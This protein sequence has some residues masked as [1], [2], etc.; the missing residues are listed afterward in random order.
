[1][2]RTTSN[3]ENVKKL[4]ATEYPVVA[5]L[6]CVEIK[7][8]DDD[9][10]LFALAGFVTIMSKSWAW[11][12]SETDRIARA[13][14]WQKAYAETDWTGCMDCAGIIE[15][16]END[17]DTREAF[18]NFIQSVTGD[19]RSDGGHGQEMTDEETDI[20]LAAGSNPTC[21]PDILYAQC[22]AVID[23]THQAVIDVLQKVEV[24]SNAIEVIHD[25]WDS[26][27]VLGT[28]DEA[29]GVDGMVDLAN[30][31]LEAVQE[32]YE[33]QWSETVGEVRDLLAYDLFCRCRSDCIINVDRILFVYANRIREYSAVPPLSQLINFLEFLAGL[34]QDANIVVYM[35]HFVAWGL[36]KL[37]RFLFGRRYDRILELL[38]LMKADEPSNDWEALEALFG[39]CQYSVNVRADAET[40]MTEENFGN[41]TD[42][43]VTE[44]LS[45]AL[46]P[47]GVWNYGAE[48]DIGAIGHATLN[49]AAAVPAAGLGRIIY[50]IGKTN[51]W[52]M[53]DAS[54]EFTASVTGKL[55]LAQN[56][57]PG[58]H[59]DNT[60][61]LV[62]LLEEV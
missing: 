57:V 58:T 54:F 18:K 52:Q 23:E 37:V 27:P 24:L 35:A 49:P 31:W 25:L 36:V 59:G 45:Y 56:D 13:E 60:G 15:C 1:M 16:L 21:D 12:G 42:F 2:P 34:E 4:A 40:N 50:C 55:Y 43:T 9:R 38:I 26:I 33:A 62:C 8:P 20:D 30:Y 17:A 29:S 28:L 47:S 51:N 53:T 48:G 44:G 11:A 19:T 7:I 6:R 22:R 10:Y 46:N 3:I 5:G 61:F 14:L 39:A 32:E 41:P